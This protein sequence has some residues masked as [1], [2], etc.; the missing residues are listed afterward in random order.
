M[1]RFINSKLAVARLS[2]TSNAVLVLLKLAVGLYGGA[3]SILSEAVHSIID[4]A[5]SSIAF[6]A[7]RQADRPP[8]GHHTYGHGKIESLSGVI[9]SLLMI[10]VALWIIYEALV[11]LHSPGVPKYLDYGI[12][13]MLLSVLINWHVSGKLFAVAGR[14]GSHALEADA[15]HLRADVW[16]SLG[17]LGGLCAIKLTG[18][19]WL[20]PVIAIAVAALIIK[21]GFS[22]TR[23]SLRELTD[24][25]LPPEDEKIIRRIINNHPEIISFHRLRTR[26]SGSQRLIDVS[27]FLDRNMNLNKAHAICDE[28]EAEIAAVFAPC[29]TVI[30]LEPSGLDLSLEKG[31]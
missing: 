11:K 4:L 24:V 22:M 29:D 21:A 6:F 25:S 10:F 20:D 1:E 23:K 31:W 27:I 8:D 19:N 12:G 5:A 3:I 16:T 7:V 28:I 18:F 17:V 26:R 15:L 14:T 13:V 2:V 30:H 9:E